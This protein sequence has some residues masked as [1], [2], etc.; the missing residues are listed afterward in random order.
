MKSSLSTP[1]TYQ[2]W[3]TD[4]I[5]LFKNP[6]KKSAECEEK[7]F[8][9][10]TEKNKIIYKKLKS[11]EESWIG[12]AKSS[13]MDDIVKIVLEDLLSRS[14]LHY[15]SMELALRIKTC[16][17]G[18]QHVRKSIVLTEKNKPVWFY[19]LLKKPNVETRLHEVVQA[20]NEKILGFQQK[21]S[22][23]SQSRGYNQK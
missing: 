2:Q 23:L 18:L 17:Q 8:K 3:L 11:I 14:T 1:Y 4:S 7:D 22:P 12:L 10:A 15:G 5:I 19:D 6:I 16:L 9:F 20:L 21:I 13:K